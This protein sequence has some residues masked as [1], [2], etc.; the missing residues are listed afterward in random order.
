MAGTR[1]P[2]VQDLVAGPLDLVQDAA[3]ELEGDPDTRPRRGE[4][5]DARLGGPVVGLGPLDL[6]GQQLGHCRGGHRGGQVARRTPKR[7][8]S[9]AGR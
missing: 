4:Q 3:V 7:S 1:D 6:E 2:A 8:R 9:S 5:L